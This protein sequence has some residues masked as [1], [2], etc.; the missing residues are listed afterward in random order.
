[1]IFLYGLH[2]RLNRME[3]HTL[4][5]AAWRSILQFFHLQGVWLGML[6]THMEWGWKMCWKWQ[7]MFFFKKKSGLQTFCLDFHAFINYSTVIY[8]FNKQGTAV[9]KSIIYH[10]QGFP[11]SLVLIHFRMC[12]NYAVYIQMDL[13]PQVIWESPFQTQQLFLTYLFTCLFLPLF[14]CPIL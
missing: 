6:L 4:R 7:F 8:I 9:E 14:R 12:W 10:W 5:M 11:R 13:W 3:L 1:M 2:R